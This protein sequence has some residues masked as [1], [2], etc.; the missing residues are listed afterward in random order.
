MTTRPRAPF[1]TV[2]IAGGAAH[3]SDLATTG[4]R[5]SPGA[6]ADKL[7]TRLQGYVGLDSP[8]ARFTSAR[9]AAE[10]NVRSKSFQIRTPL[11]RSCIRTSYRT[12]Q[13]TS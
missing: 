12:Q 10:G 4:P 8:S 1:C 9:T 5:V 6:A 2:L 7:P 13:G 3:L 11:N